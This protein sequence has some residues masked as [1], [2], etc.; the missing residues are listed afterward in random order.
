MAETVL[1][2]APIHDG[3]RDGKSHVVVRG[4]RFA[5]AAWIDGCWRFSNGAPI[6]FEPTHYHDFKA[7]GH[8]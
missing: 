5:L 2:L 4:T 8:G 1:R 6:D 7:G 3:L